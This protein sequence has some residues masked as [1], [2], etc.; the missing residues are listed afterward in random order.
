MAIMARRRGK[1]R[2]GTGH[3]TS[4]LTVLFGITPAVYVLTNTPAGSSQSPL[5]A[6]LGAGSSLPALAAGFWSLAA[7]V[8]QN[9]VTIL[10]LVAI[11]YVGI[12]VVRKLGRR[13]HI[14]KH[15]SI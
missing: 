9:W 2:R 11:A 10:I 7:N 15:L 5:T 13:G 3:T 14:T 1:S 12:R 8:I 6:I 4:L